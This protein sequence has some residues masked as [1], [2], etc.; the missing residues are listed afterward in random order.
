LA[1]GVQRHLSKPVEPVELA[2]VVA[3]V[4]GRSEEGITL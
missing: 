2:K 1:A 3:R 4:L